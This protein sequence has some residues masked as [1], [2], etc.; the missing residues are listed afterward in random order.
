MIIVSKIAPT[1]GPTMLPRPPNKDTPPSTT[2]ATEL[3]SSEVFIAGSAAPMREIRT[4][5]AMPAVVPEIA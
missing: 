1:K 5:E 2:A 3:S 4:T